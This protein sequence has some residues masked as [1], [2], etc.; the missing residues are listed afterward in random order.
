MRKKPRDPGL[1][2]KARKW[3]AFLV[4]WALETRHGEEAAKTWLWSLTPFPATVPRWKEV[5]FGAL[6]ALA[7]RKIH[8]RM[9]ETMMAKID[10][11]IERAM[12]G[13]RS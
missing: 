13:A 4:A 3:A 2:W 8:A 1:N 11:E 7:P 10:R 12:S 6:A 9:V 5:A